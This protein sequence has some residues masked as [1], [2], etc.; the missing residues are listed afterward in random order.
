MLRLTEGSACII[1]DSELEDSW[2]M[3]IPVLTVSGRSG[4]SVQM[5]GWSWEMG[6]GRGRGRRVGEWIELG[7]S[8]ET[9][10]VGGEAVER[11]GE[12][13]VEH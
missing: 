9:E 3:G 5:Y 1:H 6:V 2:K 7:F 12:T 10:G 11:S 4:C 13:G 8:G